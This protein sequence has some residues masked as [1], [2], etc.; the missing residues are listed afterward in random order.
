MKQYLATAVLLVAKNPTQRYG[1]ECTN[2]S[3]HRPGEAQC[4]H[5]SGHS[6]RCY[7]L[8]IMKLNPKNILM[9]RRAAYPQEKHVLRNV[10]TLLEAGYRVE[11][12]CLKEPSQPFQEHSD[13]LWIYRVPLEHHRGNLWNT[14][15]EYWIFFLI[16]IFLVPVRFLISKPRFI[17]IDTMPNFLVFSTLLP[18]LLGARVVLYMFELMPET[19]CEKLKVGMT[20]PIVRIMILEEKLST[21]FANRIVVYHELMARSLSIRGIDEKKMNIVYNVPLE[22]RYAAEISAEPKEAGKVYFIHHGLV[23]EHYGLQYLLRA[24]KI[25]EDHLQPCPPIQFDIVGKGEFIP[26]LRALV[27]RLRFNLVHIFFWGYVPDE[28]LVALLK[29]ADAEVLPLLSNILSPNKLF[30]LAYFGKPVLCSRVDAITYHFPEESILYFS[31]GDST[32]IAAK[33]EN[34]ILNKDDLSKKLSANIKKIYEQISWRSQ[35][36]LY[37]SIYA[38]DRS[39]L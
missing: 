29:R 21:I 15:L 5:I 7:K 1:W 17:E 24:F 25:V 20:H 22:D 36:L 28:K 34:F 14:F 30:D 18:R 32:D 35:K 26:E 3:F 13:D 9:V 19:Y 11:L 31:K 39:F 23:A 27:E 2:S 37:L 10:T 12:I 6:V 4:R 33:L 8:I 16:L 38:N